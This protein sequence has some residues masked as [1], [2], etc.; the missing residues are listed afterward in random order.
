MVYTW[1][2]WKD[3]LY[4]LGADEQCTPLP[5]D[6]PKFPLP[7]MMQQRRYLGNEEDYWFYYS[8]DSG[9]VFLN[10]NVVVKIY[11]FDDRHHGELW[12]ALFVEDIYGN[13]FWDNNQGWNYTSPIL[14]FSP[15]KSSAC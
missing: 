10:G 5:K 12:F 14:T 7:E 2:Q 4:F 8:G 13:R 6:V 9:R 1:N 3:T 11:K 15:N